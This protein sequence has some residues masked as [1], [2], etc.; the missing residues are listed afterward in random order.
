[1]AF[2]LRHGIKYGLRRIIVAVPFTTITQQTAH[3]Y[4]AIFEDGY[5]DADPV[6]LEHHSAAIEGAGKASD[7][8]DSF[9]RKRFGSASPL[10]TGMRRS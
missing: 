4:R 10:R 5:A 2:A 9:A 6:V 3:V 8:D 7:D 1:M